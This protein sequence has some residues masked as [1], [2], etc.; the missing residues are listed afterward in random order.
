MCNVECWSESQQM[1]P[2]G[3]GFCLVVRDYLGATSVSEH[4]PK[5]EVDDSVGDL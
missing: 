1:D 2:G 4:A 3:L 5:K